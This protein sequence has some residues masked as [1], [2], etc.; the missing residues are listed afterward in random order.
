ML[1]LL[2]KPLKHKGFMNYVLLKDG[3]YLRTFLEH[4]RIKYK[5][6]LYGLPPVVFLNIKDKGLK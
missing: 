2:F 1:N 4:V 6:S 5:K 3:L